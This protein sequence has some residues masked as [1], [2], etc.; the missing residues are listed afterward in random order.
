MKPIPLHSYISLLKS[1]VDT[2]QRD[3][4]EDLLF[5]YRVTDQWALPEGEDRI[6]RLNRLLSEMALQCMALCSLVGIANQRI[7]DL[8]ERVEDLEKIII[9][10]SNHG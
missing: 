6:D 1:S 10:R 3:Q 9:E 4:L 5:H 8:Q 2:Q 7:D